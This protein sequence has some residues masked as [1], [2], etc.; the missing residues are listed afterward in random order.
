MESIY[1]SEKSKSVFAL[2][3]DEKI[4]FRVMRLLKGKEKYSK[5]YKRKKE[6]LHT[7]M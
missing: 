2:L 4:C 5:R 6:R 7:Y 1:E 3:K